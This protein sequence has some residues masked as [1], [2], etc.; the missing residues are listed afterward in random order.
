MNFLFTVLYFEKGYRKKCTQQ[1]RKVMWVVLSPLFFK[2]I[3][4]NGTGGGKGGRGMGSHGHMFAC[5]KGKQSPQTWHIFDCRA[6]KG[7]GASENDRSTSSNS[8]R[9]R[10]CFDEFRTLPKIPEYFAK[11]CQVWRVR[12]AKSWHHLAEITPISG[13]ITKQCYRKIFPRSRA[14]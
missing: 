14:M 11:G 4:K 2:E 1:S 8:E 7:R 6:P 5:A 3:W 10:R 9:C 12:S 13:E